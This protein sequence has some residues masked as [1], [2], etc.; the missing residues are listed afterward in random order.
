MGCL[1]VHVVGS[2]SSS[3]SSSRSS[4]AVNNLLQKHVC[5]L[6]FWPSYLTHVCMWLAVGG[7]GCTSASRLLLCAACLSTPVRCTF[8]FARP[9]APHN[10]HDHTY[11]YNLSH[12]IDFHTS[13]AVGAVTVE[14]TG[15]LDTRSLPLTQTSALSPAR[16]TTA[17]NQST[18]DRVCLVETTRQGIRT[19]LPGENDKRPQS[20]HN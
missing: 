15:R 18:W 10:L 9:A 2:S 3:S 16:S 8:I 7:P 11:R 5:V 17:P 4:N 13:L 12:R 14:T 1:H 20:V 6:C 19:E